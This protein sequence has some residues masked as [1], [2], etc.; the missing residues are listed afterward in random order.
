MRSL[1]RVEGINVVPL[2]DIMLVL[3][4]I[5]LT[6]SSF[7]ALGKLEIALPKE[8]VAQTKL[9]PKR[10]DISI[11]KEKKFFINEKEVAQT[12][13]AQ[14]LRKVTKEDLVAISADKNSDYEDFVFV[15]DILKT[16]EIEK[17]SMVVQK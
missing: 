11:S 3:L 5:V 16:Q 1:K 6:I 9:E 8:S 4:A 14:E 13:L 17:I 7:I 10:F 15:I 12:D 2:I